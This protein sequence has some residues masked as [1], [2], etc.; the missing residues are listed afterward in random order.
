VTNDLDQCPNTPA[1]AS[2]D[3]HGCAASQLDD[4]AD[5]VTNDLDQC[6]NTP[7]GAVV[8]ANGCAA[9]QLDDD[10]DG[11]TPDSG[12]CDDTDANTYPGATEILDG[13]DNDCDGEID[14][15]LE[16]LVAKVCRVWITPKSLNID[17]KAEHAFEIHVHFCEPTLFDQS[18]PAQVSIDFGS[19]GIFD[20]SDLTTGQAMGLKPGKVVRSLTI[21]VFTSKPIEDNNPKV[22]LWSIAGVSVTYENGTPID[23]L[24]LDTKSPAK[25]KKN[26]GS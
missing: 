6:P 7:A 9:S 10:G 21:K 4:D 14:E 26:S 2:V 8:D 22:A 12:D 15:G 11:F 25:P 3:T 13:K 18:G 24:Q 16:A 20:D 19:D 23:N 1:G 5:G 17:R